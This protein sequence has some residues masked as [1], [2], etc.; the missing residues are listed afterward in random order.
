MYIGALDALGRE[1]APP[2]QYVSLID[3]FLDSWTAHGFNRCYRARGWARRVTW[4]VICLA[5]LVFCTFLCFNVITNYLATPKN[6]R[7]K[8]IQETRTEFPAVT[9]CNLSPL[10]TKKK[11]P[12][13]SVWSALADLEQEYSGG[14]G[15]EGLTFSTYPDISDDGYFSYHD[16]YDYDYFYSGDFSSNDTEDSNSKNHTNGKTDTSSDGKNDI[17]DTSPDGK[18]DTDADDDN[19]VTYDNGNTDTISDTNSDFNSD[20][21]TDNDTVD[22]SSDSRAATMRRREGASPLGYDVEGKAGP[23]QRNGRDFDQPT[24]TR[25]TED[26]A[27][28][29]IR[30][31]AP[32]GERSE[33]AVERLRLSCSKYYR[34]IKVIN[35]DNKTP[36]KWDTPGEPCPDENFKEE[37]VWNPVC[38]GEVFKDSYGGYTYTLNPYIEAEKRSSDGLVWVCILC[39]PTSCSTCKPTCI[40]KSEMQKLIS[41]D[42]SIE[43]IKMMFQKSYTADFSDIIGQFTPT[44]KELFEYATPVKDFITTCS[45]NG[46]PCFFQNFVS[47]P[48]DEFGQCYS[49]NLRRKLKGNKFR[50]PRTSTFVGP[51]SGLWLT[52]NINTARYLSL[53]SPEVGV[54]VIVHDPRTV[55]F[56]EEEG[57]NIP[58]GASSSIRIF[59]KVFQYLTDS[60]EGCYRNLPNEDIH[61]LQTCKKWCLESLY[62]KECGCY[63][64][65]NPAY[66]KMDNLKEK[67]SQ[68]CSLFNITQKLCMDIVEFEFQEKVKECNC[69]HP[70]T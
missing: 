49:F 22:G 11:L 63:K 16:D 60:R 50:E 44:K 41:D 54:R 10:A 38:R 47:W 62:W 32:S 59:K 17:I 46:L 67:P 13:N 21:D 34:F 68:H 69:V 7:M 31:A 23:K 53:L 58:P 64:G 48:S 40:E 3:D 55:P 66:N 29:A 57:F 33:A 15:C 28:R 51:G 26:E 42:L 65:Q 14:S 20:T 4:A 70:C 8:I 45:Y 56:P 25:L 30:S 12:E 37:A 35:S 19:Y 43:K 2:S 52:L 36:S 27:F 5:L 39:A 1:E 9:L 18:A 61:T 24:N 6:I